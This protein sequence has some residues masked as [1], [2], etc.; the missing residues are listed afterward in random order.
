M[1]P[2]EFVRWFEGFLDAAGNKKLDEYQTK[3]LKKKLQAVFNK[4]TKETL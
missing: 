1:K 2:E 3:V 4:K